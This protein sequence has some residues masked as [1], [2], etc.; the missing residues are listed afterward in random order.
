MLPASSIRLIAGLVKNSAADLRL[1]EVVP[2]VAADILPPDPARPA[3]HGFVAVPAAPATVGAYLASL[4]GS[5]A[6]ST[7]WD[8]VIGP[9]P[10]RALTE[11]ARDQNSRP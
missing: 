3:A 6:P 10:E 7:R 2:I 5:H 11:S 9:E 1:S 4:A 8:R